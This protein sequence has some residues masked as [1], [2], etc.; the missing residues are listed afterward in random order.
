M[1]IELFLQRTE[2]LHKRLADLSQT[3]NILLWIPPELLPDA[4]KEIQS[5]LRN[6][7]LA[8]DELY[9]QNEQLIETQNVLTVE[10][11]HYRDLFESAPDGY[12]ITNAKGIVLQANIVASKLL[13]L[14]K[15]FMVGKA[16]I[17]FIPLEERHHFRSF[18]N[19]LS[20]SD[21]DRELVIRLLQRHGE[22]FN[23]TLT[24]AV[25]RNQ[26]GKVISI[27]WLMRKI[28]VTNKT[29]L[30]V[31]NNNSNSLQNRYKY[32]YTKGENILLNPQEILYVCRGLVKLSTFCETGEE[33]LV[34]LAKAG[35]VFGSS[36]TSLNN[37]QAIALCDIDLVSIHVVEIAASSTLSYTLL[38]KIKERL[39]QTESFV[40]ICGRRRVK[41]R[42]HNFLQLLKQEIGEPV[43]DGTRLS[44]RFTHEDIA[45]ACCTTRVT[46]TR[47][48][49][50]FEKQGIISFNSTNQII[51]KDF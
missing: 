2:L 34:G 5:N 29:E 7:H 49:G 26:Q 32:K 3:A 35:M 14:S 15:P 45:S 9:Q 50:K 21:K 28:S 25:V 40:A 47:L 11:E 12:L 19:R 17:N 6:L 38:P 39:Q 20:E 48:M 37:Y 8:V 24:V 33:V 10:R 16:F 27:R 42:L 31:V 18:L 46:I 4:F 44:V 43:L 23:A 51:L 41:E 1:N 30:L 22:S 36:L 13:N